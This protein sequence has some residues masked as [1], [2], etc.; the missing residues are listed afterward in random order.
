MTL[1]H[2]LGDRRPHEPLLADELARCRAPRRA[3]AGTRIGAPRTARATDDV[4]GTSNSVS[5]RASSNT[6]VV[7]VSYW[8]RPVSQTSAAYRHTAASRLEREPHRV[9]ELLHHDTTRG[10][11]RLDEVDRA[12]AVVRDVVVDDDELVRALGR[13]LEVAEARERAA[14]ERHHHVG[15]GREVV[16]RGEQVEAGEVA[17]VRRDWN[18]V[19]NDATTRRAGGTEHVEHPEHRSERVAVGVHVARERHERR[20]RDRGRRVRDRP[21]RL[22]AR[23]S[24]PCSM[25]ATPRRGGDRMIS[26]TRCPCSIA[27]SR[28]KSSRGR[29]FNRTS[30]PRTARRCGAAARSAASTSSSARPSAA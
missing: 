16:G 22:L 30:R 25:S 7:V 3:A 1:E 6:S 4:T 9:D 19:G 12:V 29:Y 2:V 26:S 18:G 24:S 21:V 20:V 5:R 11:L 23:P 28:W 13:G 14:V 27:G 17:V 10:R 8:K 15:L